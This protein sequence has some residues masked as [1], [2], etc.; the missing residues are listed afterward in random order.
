MDF[1]VGCFQSR[2]VRPSWYTPIPL[3]HGSFFDVRIGWKRRIDDSKARTPFQV[4]DKRRPKLWVG[5][6]VQFI[7]GL[8]EKSHPVLAL[9]LRGA[10]S[11]VVANHR[12]MSAMLCRILRRT[13]K[14][15]S[16]E[17]SDVLE[18]SG[19]H[20]PE[21]RFEERIGRNLF[22]KARYQRR[23]DF[24]SAEPFVECRDV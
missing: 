18:M 24:R 15:L 23:Q 17:L 6:K 12:G 22:V 11:K 8:E 5:R 20:M 16:D 1:G 13:A 4:C 19:V 2:L 21:K 9:L 10:L 3:G 14:N 7:G